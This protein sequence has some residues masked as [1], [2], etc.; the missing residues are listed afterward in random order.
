MSTR[1]IRV[2]APLPLPPQQLRNS[3]TLDDRSPPHNARSHLPEVEQV[4][5]LWIP[6]ARL[7]ANEGEGAVVRATGVLWDG[8]VLAIVFVFECCSAPR[9]LSRTRHSPRD[10]E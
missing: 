3:A 1:P 7:S 6:C 10:P 8:G 5:L 2:S 9:D 4:V